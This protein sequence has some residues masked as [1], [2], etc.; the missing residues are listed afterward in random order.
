MKKV[1]KVIK[2][3]VGDKTAVQGNIAATES[4]RID[5]SIKG[6]IKTEGML[7]ISRSAKVTGDVY[8]QSII[9]GGSIEGNLYIQDKV[10]AY[11]K[12]EIRGNISAKSL[13]IDENV[14]FEGNC[15]IKQTGNEEK[16]ATKEEAEETKE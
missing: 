12:A 3:V 5:G 6:M 9:I 10:E 11:E 4:I 7:I 8:A 13:S 15:S 14:I 16:E 1:S 2:T